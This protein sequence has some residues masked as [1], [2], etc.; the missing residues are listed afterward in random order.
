MRILV[1]GA[2]GFIGSSVARAYQEA[3]HEVAGVD[4]LSTGQRENLPAEIHLWQAD[5]ADEQCLEGIF[6]DFRPEAI[7]H[8]AAQVNVRVS[9]EKPLEDA[10]ANVL[11]SLALLHQAVRWES[12]KVIYSSSGGAVYGEPETLPVT[13]D[14]P[15]RPLSNYGASKY[16]TELYLYAFHASSRLR[17]VILRYPN[18]FGPWQDPKGEAGVVA[19]FTTQLLQNIQPRIFG[20]G[21][22]TRDYLYIDDVVEANLRALDH[23]D[24]GVF[25]LGWGKEISDLEVF[26][27]VR[28]AVGSTVDP[29]YEQKRPGEINHICL[30]ASRARK[31]LG[32]TPKVEFARG[33][34]RV[35]KH[36]K[37][38]RTSA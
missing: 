22:K 3:G 34:E 25:N 35:V 26:Q 27:T 12:Q 32:W 2:A 36:W 23:P 16:A 38:A 17:H 28:K 21:S 30:D 6:R 9:W 20:D 7:S 5:L 29:L 33:V 8:H 13:E 10:R 18:V 14:H 19:I 11:G 1:T 31:A 24:C 15:V 4:N 37:E